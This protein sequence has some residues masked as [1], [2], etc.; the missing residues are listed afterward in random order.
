MKRLSFFVPALLAT[1]LGA[2]SLR[3][4]VSS[5]SYARESAGVGALST[6][7]AGESAP[8][9][10]H[11][12]PGRAVTDAASALAAVILPLDLRLASPRNERDLAVIRQTLRAR[13]A[14]TYIG[15]MLLARD[16]AL[17]RWPERRDEPVRVWIQPASAVT[18]WTP[19]YADEV[20]TAFLEWDA[21]DLP[22]RFQFVTD[23]A[24]AEVT[25]RWID[26]F[27]EPISGRT[28]WARNGDYWI[29][30]A[31]ISLA[32]H[33]RNGDLLDLDSM[34]A[35]ALHEIGHLLGL[36]HT[37]DRTSIMAPR[38]RVRELS[39]ADRATAQLLYAVPP[40]ALR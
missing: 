11:P 5:T 20:H 17:A 30:D 26:R 1:S 27:Q 9:E 29:T 21:V 7:S 19:A 34:K 12:G 3:T 24:S 31:A 22:A 40:G 33:H 14:G 39:E 32:V 37:A 18:D 38:V 13:Q 28:R 36:D 10:V 8:A 2:A 16:S 35:M 4:V 6:T 23:S 15:E 25:V